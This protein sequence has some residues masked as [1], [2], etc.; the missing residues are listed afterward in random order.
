MEFEQ[1]TRERKR[2]RS[3]RDKRLPRATIDEIINVA[4][5]GSIQ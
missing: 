4:K 1:L 2:I 5:W 3:S